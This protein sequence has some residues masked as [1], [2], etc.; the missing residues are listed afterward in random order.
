MKPECA[1]KGIEWYKRFLKLIAKYPNQK[2]VPN[3]TIDTVWHC[4]ILDTM[5]YAEDCHR[6]FGKFI[7]HYPYFGMNGDADERDAAFEQT[8]LIAETEFG[9]NFKALGAA[10]L[11]CSTD[12]GWVDGLQ[13]QII[14][15]ALGAVR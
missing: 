5:A 1:R 3:E 13:S 10:A 7:H 11:E 2:I 8:N 9:E 6:I 4:H 14:E 15:P 12:C